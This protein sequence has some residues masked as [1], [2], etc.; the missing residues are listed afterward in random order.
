MT[1]SAEFFERHPRT[2][3]LANLPPM[4]PHRI[5]DIPN[6]RSTIDFRNVGR[7]DVSRNRERTL[8]KKR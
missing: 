3:H 8:E 6:E 2:R 1:A 4:A 7:D 5:G